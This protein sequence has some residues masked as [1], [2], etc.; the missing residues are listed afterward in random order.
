MT[1]PA[2]DVAGPLAGIRVLDFTAL[3]QGPLAWSW[4]ALPLYPTAPCCRP[5]QVLS[6]LSLSF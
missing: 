6:I 1:E 2:P 4:P 5:R 3:L